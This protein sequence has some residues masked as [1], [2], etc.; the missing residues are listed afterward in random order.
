MYDHATQADYAERPAADC[1]VCSKPWAV[2]FEWDYTDAEQYCLDHLLEPIDG[3]PGKTLL[4]YMPD[5]QRITH[6]PLPG[7]DV[8]L[9]STA[10]LQT[11]LTGRVHQS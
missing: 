9:K 8:R 6:R 2:R 11:V 7:K 1:D 10:M 5:S 3:Q 4:D